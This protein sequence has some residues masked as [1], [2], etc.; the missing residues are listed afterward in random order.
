MRLIGNRMRRAVIFG[1]LGVSLASVAEGGAIPGEGCW[2]LEDS[3]HCYNMRR[4]VTGW[5]GELGADHTFTMCKD[6]HGNASVWEDNWAMYDYSRENLE[7]A[8][9]V[10]DLGCIKLDSILNAKAVTDQLFSNAC[11]GYAACAA[12]NAGSECQWSYDPFEGCFCYPWQLGF[13]SRLEHSNAVEC[14]VH[15]GNGDG[16]DS[17][18]PADHDSDPYFPDTYP[19]EDNGG[20]QL[21]RICVDYCTATT[22]T[23][24]IIG[25]NVT[26]TS[27]SCVDW[28][29]ECWFEWFYPLE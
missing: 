28:N 14:T 11:T 10:E 20:A 24:L 23:S 17:T 25:G 2:C 12:N 22:R 18:D 26:N 1:I 5:W 13:R 4:D 29:T 21:W 7:S 8:W 16:G 9:S 19:W 15:G 6:R 27:V 3:L